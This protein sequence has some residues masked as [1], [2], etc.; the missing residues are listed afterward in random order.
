[1]LFV[2]KYNVEVGFN[3]L[4]YAK[5]TSALV[6]NIVSSENTNVCSLLPLSAS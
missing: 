1:M 5:D 4:I 6:L 3:G 2:P